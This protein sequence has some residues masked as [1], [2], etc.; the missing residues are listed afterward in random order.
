MQSGRAG[1]RRRRP[2]PAD[3]AAPPS[4]R[5]C[6][7]PLQAQLASDKQAPL[8]AHDLWGG[9][10]SLGVPVGQLWMWGRGAPASDSS[11]AAPSCC[12]KCN[13][14]RQL[15][16]SWIIATSRGPFSKS[17]STNMRSA[18]R[19][20]M[21]ATTSARACGDSA[22][23]AGS[24]SS[25]HRTVHLPKNMCLVPWQE[26]TR[27]PRRADAEVRTWWCARSSISRGG[28]RVCHIFASLRRLRGSNDDSVLFFVP[29][30][31]HLSHFLGRF[32]MSVEGIA[33]GRS[34]AGSCHI[35]IAICCRRR[36]GHGRRGHLGGR[37][38]SAVRR[39]GC[40]RRDRWGRGIEE[41]EKVADERLGKADH[42][43]VRLAPL[44]VGIAQQ[45]V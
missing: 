43:P 2:S 40:R 13:A 22:A 5:S 24:S 32:R 15:Y 7:A 38:G 33:G 23:S 29:F 6:L 10:S 4:R 14:L 16:S 9:C 18:S 37:I 31:Q 12:F 39:C 41:V 45:R 36:W 11:P 28:S 34:I 42:R 3:L 25:A 17:S 35:C 8:T 30:P 19:R 44:D 21:L 20:W 1:R 27:R 26:Q